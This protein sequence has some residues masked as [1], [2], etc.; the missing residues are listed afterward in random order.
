MPCPP[1]TGAPEKYFV[2]TWRAVGRPWWIPSAHRW[3]AVH[4]AK[5]TWS[6]R[7]KVSLF[8]EMRRG[9]AMYRSQLCWHSLTST[10]WAVRRGKTTGGAKFNGWEAWLG[11][12]AGKPGW[13]A[14][15]GSLV[16]SLDYRF[17][18]M[19][20]PYKASHFLPH[21]ALLQIVACSIFFK[22][23]SSKPARLTPTSRR[24]PPAFQSR[25]Q[26]M[27]AP[28]PNVEC[29]LNGDTFQLESAACASETSVLLNTL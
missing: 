6:C 27:A 10:L 18:R 24:W 25:L 13:E 15:L 8:A 23:H 7:R 4:H 17:G 19:A 22:P 26:A 21:V 2:D 28:C 20:A 1:G 29:M 9:S 5:F 3:I 12:L 16:A 14:W 11:G